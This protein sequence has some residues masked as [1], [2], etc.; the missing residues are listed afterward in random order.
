MDFPGKR[1]KVLELAQH[2]GLQW[3]TVSGVLSSAAVYAA[4]HFSPRFNASTNVSARVALAVSPAFF[5][6]VAIAEK[7]M[8]DASRD[9]EA[10]GI[11]P[12][13]HVAA[14]PAQKRTSL[15]WYHKAANAAYT[16]PFGLIVGAGVPAVGAIFWAQSKDAQHL[17]FSQKVMHTRVLGQMTVLGVLVGTMMFRDWMYKNG[18]LFLEHEEGEAA[19]RENESHDHESQ[20]DKAG[21]AAVAAH[22][23]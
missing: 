20:L 9:P 12:P 13:G 1:E 7:T 16:H 3:A 15:A 14:V 8:V 21:T 19:H 4:H 23:A 18:G 11:Y 17:K 6:Y 10:F 5:A 2:K 22:N